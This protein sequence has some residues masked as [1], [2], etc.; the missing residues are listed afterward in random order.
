MGRSMNTNQRVI[1]LIA[2]LVGSIVTACGSG[3]PIDSSPAP[4][5]SLMPGPA[6]TSVSTMTARPSMPTTPASA[7]VLVNGV[8]IDGTGADPVPDA[9]VLILGSQI[10]AVGRRD[11]VEIP[12]DAQII[13]VQGGTILPGLID[14]HVHLAYSN[15]AR[16]AQAGI[17]TVRSLGE[18]RWGSVCQRK[19]V[20]GP[21]ARVVSAG[22]L[23]TVPKGYPIWLVGTSEAALTVSSPEQARN[24]T[25]KL[26]GPEICEDV[27]K[28]ALDAGPQLTDEELQAIVGVAHE[29]NSKVSAHVTTVTDLKKALASGVDDMAHMVRDRLPDEVMDQMI[30]QDV[31]VVPTLKIFSF[32][33]LASLNKDNLKRFVAA[34]GKVAVGTDFNNTAF[35]EDM[36]LQEMEAMQE[37]GMTPMQVL[38]A[39]TRNGAHVSN[40]EDTIGTLETGKIAD[41]LV[42]KGDP[43]EDLKVLADVQLVIHG[44]VVI[45]DE[46]P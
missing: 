21:I 40:L 1:I 39:A 37:A 12:N 33:R 44:G 11:Q 14:A 20:K 3:Q 4:T 41:V 35:P 32:L 7:I 30:A 29:R 36:Y 46:I 43:L 38:V 13:D 34:G 24:W 42:V 16:W 19:S 28:V 17:T 27:I 31:Y 25:E 23:M 15:A 6:F 26:L 9:V 18:G 10:V 5:L 2:L 45:R 22:P 8:L